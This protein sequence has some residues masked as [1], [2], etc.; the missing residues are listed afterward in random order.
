MKKEELS[1]TLLNQA[2]SLGL[3]TEWTEQWGEPDQQGFN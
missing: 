3:C 1:R 2:V